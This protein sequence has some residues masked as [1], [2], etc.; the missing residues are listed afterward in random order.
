MLICTNLIKGTGKACAWHKSPKLW[1]IVRIYVELFASEEKAGALDPTGS[2]L[3]V[4]VFIVLMQMFLE[5]I[6]DVNCQ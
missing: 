1:F 5:I 4:I 6:S 3:K 2:K